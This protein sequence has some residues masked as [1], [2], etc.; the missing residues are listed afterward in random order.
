VSGYRGQHQAGLQRATARVLAYGPARADRKYG[1]GVFV[2]P[3]LLATCAHNLA[4]DGTAPTVQYRGHPYPAEVLVAEPGPPQADA[5][6]YSVP[7]VALLRV[8]TLDHDTVPLTESEPVEGA[9]LYCWGWIVVDRVVMSDP[10]LLTAGA[11]RELGEGSESEARLLKVDGAQVREGSSGAG[12]IDLASGQLIGLMKVS[13]DPRFVAGGSAIP[14]SLMLRTFADARHDVRAANAE[15]TRDAD[16]VGRQRARFGPIWDDL[17]DA[18]NLTPEQA[19]PLLR[20]LGSTWNER[21]RGEDVA[22]VLLH[23]ELDDL[24]AGMVELATISRQVEAAQRLLE[25]SLPF[26]LLR[27]RPWVVDDGVAMLAAERSLPRPRVVHFSVSLERTVRLYTARAATPSERCR[28]VPL[29]PLDGGPPVPGTVLPVGFVRTVQAELL[30]EMG[31]T[32]F[33]PTD[34]DQVDALEREWLEWQTDAL[35]AGQRLLF[36]LPPGTADAR[37]ID[38]LRSVFPGC[39]FALRSEK[40]TDSLAQDVDRVL[41]LPRSLTDPDETWGEDRFGQTMNRIERAANRR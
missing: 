37:T 12:V 24:A 14:T 16:V 3:G 19:R 41:N 36:L 11:A 5:R 9:E 10:L 39:A 25:L 34:P 7:D 20:K 30:D 31:G 18:A 28:L 33:D 2:A 27:T 40:L 6:V 17:L 1:T 32:L 26:V 21:F 13:T 8:G 15:A 38:D 29:T 23:R 4:P 35:R 22:N